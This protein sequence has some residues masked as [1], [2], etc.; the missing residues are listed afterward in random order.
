MGGHLHVSDDLIE[1]AGFWMTL[2]FDI[3]MYHSCYEKRVIHI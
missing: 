2:I 1:V 3:L